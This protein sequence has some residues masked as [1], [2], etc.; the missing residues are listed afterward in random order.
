MKPL[1]LLSNDDGYQARGIH[2]LVEM[3]RPIAR[4][5]VVAPDSARSGMACAC[6]FNQPVYKT[7]IHQD[8]DVTIWS[9]TG[10]PVDCIKLAFNDI[11]TETPAMIIG[12]IN[13]GDNSAINAHYSGTMG[14]AFEGCMK[15]VPSVA[16]SLDNH[17]PDADFAPCAE[18]I[19]RITR[20]VLEHGLPPHTCLNVNFPQVPVIKGVRVCRMAYGDWKQEFDKAIHP[21]T[22]GDYYWLTGYFQLEETTNTDTDRQ[23][24]QQ[25]Y[26][27]ITPV[28]LD[29]TD[30][31]LK[32][33]LESIFAADPTL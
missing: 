15:G 21:R 5:I 11:C 31:A 26:A 7:L 27:A 20:Y 9:C 14:I 2:C 30:Y 1:I 25:G 3:L 13:H 12:G 19:V 17:A 10:T 6:T 16:F 22:G 24:L 32:Q 28:T 23:A 4:M 18:G 8:E 29:L 33:Q